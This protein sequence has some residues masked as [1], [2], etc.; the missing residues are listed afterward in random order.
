MSFH[1]TFVRNKAFG[2]PFIWCLYLP[3]K[4]SFEFKKNAIYWIYPVII[5][6]I[7]CWLTYELSVRKRSKEERNWQKVQLPTLLQ[8][9][10]VRTHPKS[11]FQIEFE[12]IVIDFQLFLF[13]KYRVFFF[14][15]TRLLF[16]YVSKKYWVIKY[17]IIAR[18]QSSELSHYEPVVAIYSSTD[19]YITLLYVCF[20]LK[21]PY[22]IM[23]P[24]D[25][26]IKLKASNTIIMPGCLCIFSP[27]GTSQ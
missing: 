16:Y 13:P 2:I 9:V 17:Q 3:C 12:I 4:I 6:S 23:L 25:I 19:Q 10:T 5:L 7:L 15:F 21:A 18:R 24:I 26:K 22:L 8:S 11:S 27:L 20:F 1:V 14:F